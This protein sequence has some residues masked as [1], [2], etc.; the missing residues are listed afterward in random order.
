MTVP[1]GASVGAAGV[2]AVGTM[3]THRRQGILRRVMA[4]LLADARRHQD[5]V[6]ILWASEGSIYQRFG[7]GIGALAARFEIDQARAKFREPRPMQGRVRFIGDAEAARV[8]PPIFNVV[9]AATP[10]MFRRTQTWWESEILPDPE[11]WRRGA[12]FFVVHET[13]GIP[14]GYAFYRVKGDWDTGV[15][16]SQM[17]VREMVAAT[18][19]A[20]RELWDFLFSV[21]L[22]QTVR[23]VVQRAD[24]PLLLLLLEPGR[25]HLSLDDAFWV[26]MVDIERSLTARSYAAADRIVFELADPF[27]PEN[28]GHWLLDTNG[29][30]P[31]VERTEESADLAL[32]VNDLANLYLGAFSATDLGAA[33]RT[34]ERTAGA[35]A[36]V[37][38]LFV[39]S[40]KPWNPTGF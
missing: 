7:Y 28:S 37:D 9:C 27:M 6:A 26:R 29:D 39:T 30:R 10:G 23:A 38:R 31:L 40:R 21:D 24:H 13:R 33:G 18:T 25:L 36:R 17:V 19:I 15:S 1:G 5:A 3:P 4:E 14:D 11:R 2:T 22:I 35:R 12:K 8:L 34:T 20:E 16:R 32:D